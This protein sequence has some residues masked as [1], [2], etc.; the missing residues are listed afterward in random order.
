MMNLLSLCLIMDAVELVRCWWSLPIKG[1]N[2]TARTMWAV[3][4]WSLSGVLLFY[5]VMAI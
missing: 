5:T 2:A 3:I 4:A 1:G